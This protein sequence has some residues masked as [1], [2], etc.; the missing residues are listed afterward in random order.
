MRGDSACA[1]TSDL[2]WIT[3][4]RYYYSEQFKK[5]LHSLQSGKLNVPFEYVIQPLGVKNALSKHAKFRSF[6]LK[7]K[8]SL[9]HLN[10]LIVSMSKRLIFFSFF[11]VSTIKIDYLRLLYTHIENNA[12][13]AVRKDWSTLHRKFNLSSM[14]FRSNIIRPAI[15]RQGL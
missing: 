3:L 6:D 10:V 15:E 13:K 8:V 12:T 7:A 14:F 2:Y 4:R 1:K 9:F 5:S 11:R